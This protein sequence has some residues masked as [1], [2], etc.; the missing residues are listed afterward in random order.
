MAD[1]HYYV[2]D[3]CGCLVTVTDGPIPEGEQWN[4][5]ECG[6]E[7]AWEF[8]D[9]QAAYDHGAHIQRG[10]ASGVFRQLT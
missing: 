10:T 4:C 2:C 6:S 1:L 3:N 8:T 5:D 9:K 7:R